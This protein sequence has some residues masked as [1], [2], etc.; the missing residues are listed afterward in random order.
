MINSEKNKAYRKTH[1]FFM[2]GWTEDNFIHFFS[3]CLNDE[4]LKDEFE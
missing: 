2:F 1:N 3:D 4:D